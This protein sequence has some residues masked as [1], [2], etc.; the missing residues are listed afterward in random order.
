M[1]NR[2][3]G[4]RLNALTSPESYRAV[5]ALLCLQPGIPLL[6]MGQE[7]AASTP[8]HYFTDHPESLGRLV[9]AGRKREL[10]HFG[11]FAR[12]LKERALPNP[13]DA[14]FFEASKLRWDESHASPHRETRELYRRALEL[15]RAVPFLPGAGFLRFRRGGNSGWRAGCAKYSLL[16]SLAP[17]LFSR[18]RF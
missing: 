10:E 13:Q 1:G 9:H 12:E 8:F 3:F 18:R 15:R 7:W 14:D 6:F 5:S 16:G 2:P 4:D 17:A 11:I